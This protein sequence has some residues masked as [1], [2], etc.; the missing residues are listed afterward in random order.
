MPLAPSPKERIILAA[1]ALFAEHGIDGVSLRQISAASGSGNNTAVQYHFGTKDQLVRA[2][3]EYRLPYLHARRN[4]LA[5]QH[6]PD[7]L[8]G[9]VECL[10]LP[11]LEQGEQEG[12]NYL[13]FVANLHTH[14]SREVFDQ[15]APDYQAASNAFRD[16]FRAYLTHIPAPLRIHRMSQAVA[17]AIHA[18]ADRE[19]ARARGQHVLSF[20]AHVADLFDGLV[21]YLT[22]PASP[23]AIAACANAGTVAMDWLLVP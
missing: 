21:G 15:F 22:A 1:E 3:F 17:F 7:D 10:V 18:G 19:R 9:W 8:R 16:H 23:A 20:A 5:A 12:S 6:R 2:I 11:I 4:L 14:G 13:S